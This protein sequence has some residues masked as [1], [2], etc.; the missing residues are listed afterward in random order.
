MSINISY[1]ATAPLAVHHAAS[2]VGIRWRSVYNTSPDPQTSAAEEPFHVGWVGWAWFLLLPFFSSALPL[3]LLP[4]LGPQNASESALPACVSLSFGSCLPY[5][6][7][8]PVMSEEDRRPPS[9]LRGRATR[10]GRGAKASASEPAADSAA[11]NEDGDEGGGDEGNGVTAAWKVELE[12]IMQGTHA[13]LVEA[14]EPHDTKMKAVV[15]QADRIKQLQIANIDALF[16]CEK[17]MAEDEHKAQLEFFKQ[18]LIDSIEEKQKKAAQ[19]SGRRSGGA[20]A[21]KAAGLEDEVDRTGGAREKEDG[22]GGGG[23]GGGRRRWRRTRR[24]SGGGGE[25]RLLSHTPKP[26]V[27]ANVDCHNCSNRRVAI[28]HN[29]SHDPACPSSD[30][31]CTDGW[32]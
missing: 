10:G 20:D 11:A 16:E 1:C 32:Q 23:G 12:S 17:K 9:G 5:V 24:R 8:P 25:T 3:R 15:G 29:G 21:G 14:L 31:W 28:T 19:Q 18:R 13:L 26:K 27:Q 30:V 4:T 7:P 6:R 2:W 22:G